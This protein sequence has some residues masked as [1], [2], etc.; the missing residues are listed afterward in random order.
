MNAPQ[1]GREAVIPRTLPPGIPC[2][3][4]QTMQPDD[5]Q[6]DLDARPVPAFDARAAILFL[7]EIQR[8]CKIGSRAV[9][10]VGLAAR[11]D[12]YTND[13]LFRHAGIAANA[14]A[15]ISKILWPSPAPQPK[16][17][18]EA[19][20]TARKKFTKTRGRELRRMLGM[21]KASPL[22]GS[23]VRN[24]IEHFDERLD[25]RL[26]T[27]ERNI[28]QSMIGPRQFVLIDSEPDSQFYL[29]RYDPDTTEYEILEA[30]MVLADVRHAMDDLSRRVEA[31]LQRLDPVHRRINGR[32]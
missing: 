1:T 8:H 28:I 12:L 13:D 2:W 5:P 22:Y 3:Q 10:N 17:E 9:M 16:Y 23:Q 19:E 14:A 25:R 6:D 15:M 29:H 26:M 11:N 18:T 27:P 24:A 30:R 31:Q 4:D 7:E 21:T 32:A 20:S